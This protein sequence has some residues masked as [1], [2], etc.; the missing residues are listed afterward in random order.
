METET[1]SLTCSVTSLSEW[2]DS[3][4][5]RSHNAKAP[6]LTNQLEGSLTHFRTL[7]DSWEENFEK[8]RTFSDWLADASETEAPA[9]DATESVWSMAEDL[10]TQFATVSGLARK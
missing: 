5:E 10:L 8:S 1:S 6:Y 4:D 2:Y 3:D 7:T 9:A